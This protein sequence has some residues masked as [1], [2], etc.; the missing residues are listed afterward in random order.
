MPKSSLTT[1]TG[2]RELL[3]RLVSSYLGG[4]KRLRER[5]DPA[6]LRLLQPVGPRWR[7]PLEHIGPIRLALGLAA[8]AALLFLVTPSGQPE[9]SASS[10][11][12]ASG[13]VAAPARSDPF[14]ASGTA[15]DITLKLAAVLGLAYVSLA[16]LRR[17]T[18]GGGIGQRNGA[19]QILE[20]TS[21]APNR[22]VYLVR[23]GN[24]RLVL[25]VTTAQITTLAELGPDDPAP[26]NLA[27]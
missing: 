7:A 17:Y 8:F 3:D 4:E 2:R 5:I 22:A 1:R 25:G 19:L 6:W 26:A 10:L 13:Q 18:V 11:P 15:L 14:D 27:P 21:L 12:S 16:V 20:S 24:K 23:A 9:R